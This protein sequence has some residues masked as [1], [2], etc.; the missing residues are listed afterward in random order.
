MYKIYYYL[1]IIVSIRILYY[2][3]FLFKCSFINAIIIK[4]K[5]VNPTIAPVII[6]IFKGLC[7]FLVNPLFS[8]FL[9]FLK[10]LIHKTTQIQLQIMTKIKINA[11]TKN[12]KYNPDI[13]ME[14][15]GCTQCP[16]PKKFL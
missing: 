4:N 8:S 10:Y 11:K 13:S 7:F 3:G 16:I 6:N 9:S 1:N 2:R 12:P 15:V 14:S 5:R